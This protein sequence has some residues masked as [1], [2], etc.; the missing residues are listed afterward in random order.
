MWLQKRVVIVDP[1]EDEWMRNAQNFV[2]AVAT[3][4]AVL[5]G[6]FIVFLL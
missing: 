2:S 6:D 3:V 1:N 5:I 4:V